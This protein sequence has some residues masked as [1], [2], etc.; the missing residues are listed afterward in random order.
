MTAS[1][2]GM[3][4]K[5]A[6]VLGGGQG[7]GEATALLLAEVGCNVAVLD[8][9][10]ERAKRVAAQVKAKGRRSLALR[11]DALD[12][13]S[14]RTMITRADKE[15]GGID[16]MATIVG[17]AGW[18]PSIDMT[19]ETWDKDQQRNLRYFFFAA[20]SAA[21]CMI[22]RGKPGSIA[23][24]V[25][26][27]GLRSAPFHASYGAAKA[28]LVNLVRTLAV[29]WAEHGIRVNAVAPGAIVTPRIP[30]REPQEEK[31]TLGLTPMQ[32]RGFTDDIGKALL[33]FLSNLSP[34]V[35]GQTLAVDGG[36]LSASLFDY[37]GILKQASGGATLGLSDRR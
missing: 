25:S 10:Y 31:K 15:I 18:A 14:L 37:G 13:A 34:Y 35:T 8:L 23:C 26:V 36:Y 16:A 12:D 17:M 29:E 6:L 7:M 24:V 30:L 33:F 1:L 22:A 9:E 32:R 11:V 21:R 5:S 3:E 19:P 2:F 20:Q 4:G 27:D 28:G